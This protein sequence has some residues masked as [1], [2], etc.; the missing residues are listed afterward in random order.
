[1][2]DPQASGQPTQAGGRPLAGGRPPAATSLHDEF[3]GPAG[4]RPDPSKWTPQ[5]WQDDVYPPVEGIYR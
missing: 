1:M 3:D 5:T 2:P 4:P